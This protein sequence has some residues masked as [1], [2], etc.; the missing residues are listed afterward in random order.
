[1]VLACMNQYASFLLRA[2]VTSVF[3]YCYAV[4]SF[5]L[6]ALHTFSNYKQDL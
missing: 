3:V 2:K 1:M 4:L 6:E 5:Y